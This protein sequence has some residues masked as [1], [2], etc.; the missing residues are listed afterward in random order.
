VTA[1]PRPPCR[2][3]S[4]R[5]VNRCRGLCWSCYADTS[6]RNLYPRRVNQLPPAVVVFCGVC[7]RRR[8]HGGQADGL[9]CPTCQYADVGWRNERHARIDAHQQRI[10]AELVRM[11]DSDAA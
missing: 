2:H 1:A 3:C 9:T 7:G 6:I 5:P 8:Y 10:Q 4:A 11:G